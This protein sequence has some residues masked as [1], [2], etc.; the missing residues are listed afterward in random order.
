MK[1]TYNFCFYL[2]KN[3]T[4][5]DDNVDTYEEPGTSNVGSPK[6]DL[7][8][9]PSKIIKL[10]AYMGIRIDDKNDDQSHHQTTLPFVPNEE[11][12]SV[13]VQSVLPKSPQKI[14]SNT[15]NA[16][17]QTYPPRRVL[18]SYSKSGSNSSGT[19][20][21]NTSPTIYEEQLVQSTSSPS[22]TTDAKTT[23]T[24]PTTHLKLTKNETAAIFK[25]SKM[26]ISM[27]SSSMPETSESIL[28]ANLSDL[29]LHSKRRKIKAN[30]TENKT[31]NLSFS[32]RLSD[33]NSHFFNST[34]V[35]VHNNYKMFLDIR[36]EV[37]FVIIYSFCSYFVFIY[38]FLV[39][40]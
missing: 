39:C 37:N 14:I 35:P 29:E 24:L 34:S 8:V 27:P 16:V 33:V 13:S 31:D 32:N 5:L 40:R 2:G 20:S 17:K 9:P 3:K 18:R 22:M 28:T 7:N 25:N 21:R 26:S 12:Q 15:I 11:S 23:N 4:S 30:R 10:N 1:S 38:Y 36:K 19:P 6:D